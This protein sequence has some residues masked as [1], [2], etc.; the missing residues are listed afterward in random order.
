MKKMILGVGFALA[1]FAV[2]GGQDL[3]A[4]VFAG[5]FYD[6]DG[7]RLAAQIQRFLDAADVGPP[8]AARIPA[9]IVPH[10]GYVY[11]GP[12]AAFG[13]K[14]VRGSGVRSVIILAPSHRYGFRGGA[15]WPRGGFA[16]PLGTAAVD[17]AL[18]AEVLRATGFREIP[19]AFAE[20]HAVEVQVPFIQT[21]LPGAKIVPVVLGGL[22]ERG[23]RALAN[24]LAGFL[25]RPGILAVCSTDMSHYLPKAAANRVDAETAALI[26]DFRA[27]ELIRKLAEGANILCGGTA[28]AAVLLAARKAGASEVRLLHYADSSDAGA[29]TDGVVGYLAAA[30]LAAER[31]PDVALSDEEK[32]GLLRL[33]RTAVE[34]SVRTGRAPDADVGADAPNLTAARG[35]FVTIKKR[36]RLRGCIGFAEPVLPLATAVV[37]AA[38]AA[39]TEDPRFP[40]V[41]ESE[42][43]ELEYELSVLTPARRIQNPKEVRVGTHG[44]IIAQ[45]G[46]RGLLLPQVPV[47][48]GWNRDRFLRQAC[49]KAGLPETAWQTGAEIYV[50]EAIVFR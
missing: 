11:S 43:G 2:A 48:Q 36:G 32:K 44:L 30:V 37:R 19:E 28:V 49:L 5:Q 26:R 3:R 29:P 38:A 46:R 17:E 31:A 35:A 13:Y 7:G 24:D 22:D 41:D 15:V 10:A 39:A 25:S 33:A 1:A 14:L 4:P 23:V 9:I 27:D 50:F 34:T 21:V 47:E 8:P 6:A 20:E 12:T 40:P 16:T 42:L 45:G 18:A